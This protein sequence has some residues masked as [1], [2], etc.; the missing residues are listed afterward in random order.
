[1]CS[2]SNSFIV[3][4]TTTVVNS[5]QIPI[6]Q[7]DFNWS[8]TNS[9][10][11]ITGLSSQFPH[12]PV[13]SLNSHYCIFQL[14]TT[15]FTPLIPVSSWSTIS[16]AV[17]NDHHMP[18]F[19]VHRNIFRSTFTSHLHCGQW[20][21]V[22]DWTQELEYNEPRSIPGTAEYR[23]RYIRMLSCMS[24]DSTPALGWCT[25]KRVAANG[26]EEA[27]KLIFNAP[28]RMDGAEEAEKKRRPFSSLRNDPLKMRFG[29]YLP[30][31]CDKSLL[32]TKH[33]VTLVVVLVN[34]LH[35]VPGP[36][37]EGRCNSQQLPCHSIDIRFAMA[38]W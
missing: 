15:T 14:I 36:G 6:S 20:P 35:V 9:L 31:F 3:P 4:W 8:R 37:Q 26:A 32:F 27:A 11:T 19:I 30:S 24:Q 21:E 34:W 5:P 12:C 13:L 17:I 2:S 38:S 28:Q 23:Y 33:S 10:V 25:S 29:K 16:V 7:F 22:P 18:H 1:M